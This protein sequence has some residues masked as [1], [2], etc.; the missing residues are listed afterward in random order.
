MNAAVKSTAAFAEG[1][2]GSDV[3]P[4]MTGRAHVPTAAT[5]PLS[6]DV[7]RAYDSYTREVHE[8]AVGRPPPIIFLNMFSS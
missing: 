7:L 3:T 2:M 8:A 1:I 5:G 6:S 4:C